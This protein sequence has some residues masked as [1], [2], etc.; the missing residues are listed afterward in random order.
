MRDSILV[1]EVEAHEAVHRE[2]ASAYASCDV[3]LATL[4]SAVLFERIVTRQEF[5]YNYFEELAPATLAGTSA[6]FPYT[7]VEG[8]DIATMGYSGTGPF[9]GVVQE[10]DVVV[11]LPVG[12]ADG[13]SNSGC[14]P[15]DFAGIAVFLASRA[16]DFVTGTA[17]PVDGGY[18]VQ[19]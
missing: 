7:Y 17:I 15:E 6:G 3:F 8:T 9:S 10:V 12:Q 2:Q 13:T 11:P 5:E 4:T 18:S 1:A 19:G 14:E 16:S